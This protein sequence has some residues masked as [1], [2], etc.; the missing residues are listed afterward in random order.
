MKI[1]NLNK[2]NKWIISYKI[3]IKNNNTIMEE[4][5]IIYFISLRVNISLN[6]IIKYLHLT[7]TKK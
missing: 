3:L 5:I 7:K 1:P 2:N 6:A 4:E